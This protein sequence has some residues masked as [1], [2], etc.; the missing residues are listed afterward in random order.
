MIVF[1]HHRFRDSR[2][3]VVL[4]GYEGP[5]TLKELDDLLNDLHGLYRYSCSRYLLTK[6]PHCF[7]FTPDTKYKPVL[8]L[9][10]KS[11]GLDVIEDTLVGWGPLLYETSKFTEL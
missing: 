5:L 11:Y 6:S 1:K 10:L 7:K 3:P 2:Y 8:N 9:L 4:L